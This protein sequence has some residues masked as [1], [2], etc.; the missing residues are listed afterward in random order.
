MGFKQR[1]M[2]SIKQGAL[3][4]IYR[5]V[6]QFDRAPSPRYINLDVSWECNLNC[7]MCSVRQRVSKLRKEN[8]SLGRF[9]HILTQLP[10]LRH[11]SIM[12]LG[13]PMMSP[14]FFEL[15]DMAQ[16]KNIKA[17]VITNGT[18]LGENNLKRLNDNL[19]RVFISIDSPTPEKYEKIRRGAKLSEVV[20]NVRRLRESKPKVGLCLLVVLMK[21]TIEDLPELVKL[22]KNIGAECVGLSHIV[23]LDK[24]NDEQHVTS[25]T[26]EAKY[27]LEK[28]EAMAKEYK[29]G[30][31]P[32]P[33]QPRMRPCLQ[34]WFQPFIMVN[35]DVYPCTFMDRSPKPVDTE[36]YAGVPIKVPFHQ[37]R[38][39][40]IFE[41]SF[42]KIWN[43]KDFRLLRKVMRESEGGDKLTIEELNL[44]RQRVS[45][46]ETFSYCRVCLWRWSI[47]C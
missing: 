40:N 39:G 15:L 30:L 5:F 8:L 24:R 9:E 25:D 11:I 10:K 16:S 17:S 13:E 38:M 37:Y 34:P 27:Y 31:I 4:V 26:S 3:L 19:V 45:L 14:H 41:E 32:R 20:E 23:S 44:R 22:A 12:G 46:E 28:A 35:G 1:I 43:G 6:Q 7:I 29:I 42:D 33:L 2:N 36:W 18:L 47:A 21:E